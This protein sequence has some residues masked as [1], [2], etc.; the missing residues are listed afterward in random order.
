MAYKRPESVLVLVY[1]GEYEVLLL[2]RV[3]PAGFWQSVTGSLE[4]G[5]TPANAAIREL[6]EETGLR[7]VCVSSC[8]WQNQFEIRQP[9]RRR[10]AP[11][12]T[13]NTEHVFRCRLA[14]KPPNIQLA[15]DEHSE[16]RWFS[17]PHALE[18][19]SSST[20]RDALWRFVGAG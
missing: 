12:V 14:D 6:S 7:D 10:Y 15:E 16:Y 8:D 13:H 3:E 4:H 1:T 11:D 5:E 2:N 19:V 17:L 20:N 9:W 18:Q